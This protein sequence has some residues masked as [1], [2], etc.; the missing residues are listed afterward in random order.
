MTSARY[1]AFEG[2]EG[3]G[4][5]TQ[6]AHYADAI[7]AVLTRETGGTDIGARLREI[8]HDTSIDN[9][10]ARSEALIAAADRAQHLAEVVRPAL[11]AGR[12]VV[13]DRSVYSTLAYQGYGRQ[14]DIDEVRHINQWATDGLWPEIVVFIDTPDEV[15]AERMSRRNLDRF[16]AAGDDFHERV[17]DGFRTMAAADPE[18]WI[19][20]AAVGSIGDVAKQI[21][22]A[23]AVRRSAR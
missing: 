10:A 23:L 18:R 8:L 4:K 12:T 20:V 6:A 21:E 7:G 11:D 9:L 22:N 5:S 17:I 19:T 1:I 14:L 13:S 2:A 3:C 15:I 16:E